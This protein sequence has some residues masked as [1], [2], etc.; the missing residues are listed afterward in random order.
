LLWF[1]GG[2]CPVGG[3]VLDRRDVAELPREPWARM[4]GKGTF[5]QLLGPKQADRGCYVLELP[6][7]QSTNPE[8]HLY[9]EVLYIMEG[10]GSTEIWQ[11]GQSKRTFEWGPGAIFAIPLNARHRLINGSGESVLILAFTRAPRLFKLFNNAEFILNCNY[12]FTDRY[13][14]KGDAWARAH[15]DLLGGRLGDG[16]GIQRLLQLPSLR[17]PAYREL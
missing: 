15:R 8:K 14:G 7:G 17:F 9:D 16:T 1:S 12:V 11:E 13:D 2:H 4:G 3:F 10:R 5:I 6:V